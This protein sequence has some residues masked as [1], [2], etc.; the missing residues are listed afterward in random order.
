MSIVYE[1][2]Y[3]LAAAGDGSE[4]GSDRDRCGLAG[5]GVDAARGRRSGC[6]CLD[7]FETSRRRCLAC[8]WRFVERLDTVERPLRGGRR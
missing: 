2:G 6:L 3:Q 4:G 7:R 8:A 5:D 1:S